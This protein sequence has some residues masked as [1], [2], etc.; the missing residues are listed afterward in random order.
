MPE[1]GRC[2]GETKW[3]YQ[4]LVVSVGG[5]ERHFPFV[6]LPDADQVAFL[7]SSL[8]NT[9]VPWMRSNAVN[10]RDKGYS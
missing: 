2:I 1:N 5:V 6:P 10:M 4:V 8:V 3:H 9:V 7:R